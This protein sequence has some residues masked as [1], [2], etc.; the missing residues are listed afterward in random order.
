MR[1]VGSPGA[2]SAESFA[3]PFLPPLRSQDLRPVQRSG[4]DW[5]N[6]MLIEAIETWRSHSSF[7]T[8][9]SFH[10]LQP[11]LDNPNLSAAMR[12]RSCLHAHRSGV[13][14][15]QAHLL[16]FKGAAEESLNAPLWRNLQERGT[17]D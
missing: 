4:S 2:V 15:S 12:R 14:V 8:G 10:C 1:I 3:L 6:A 13:A 17:L 11:S 9:D 5:I 16:T 7:F